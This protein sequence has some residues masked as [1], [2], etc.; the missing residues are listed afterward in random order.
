MFSSFKG[1]NGN[2]GNGDFQTPKLWDVMILYTEDVLDAALTFRDH[3]VNDIDMGEEEKIS[4]VLCDQGEVLALRGSDLSNFESGCNRSRF[5]FIFLTN[6]FLQDKNKSFKGEAALLDSIES[7]ENSEY[8]VPVYTEK[9]MNTCRI[10]NT[11]ALKSLTGIKYY[12]NDTG[13]SEYYRDNVATLIKS[14]R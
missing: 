2:A 5:L 13:N 10:M 6:D 12:L 7:T 4:A 8:V 14:K 11:M 1:P 9:D 3:L